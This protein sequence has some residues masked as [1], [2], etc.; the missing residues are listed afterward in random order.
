MRT[1]KALKRALLTAGS[2][3]VKN[4]IPKPKK[5]K[6]GKVGKVENRTKGE[7]YPPTSTK[8]RNI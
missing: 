4:S 7:Y 5:K 6:T 1:P 8:Y 2:D 3:T